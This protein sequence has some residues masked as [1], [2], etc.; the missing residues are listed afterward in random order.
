MKGVVAA[1]GEHAIDIDKIAN[2]ADLGA[3]NN[4]VVSEAVFLRGVRGSDR[5]DDHGFHHHVACFEG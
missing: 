4:F 5:G 1:S 3:E 2:A